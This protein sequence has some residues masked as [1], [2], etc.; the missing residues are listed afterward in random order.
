MHCRSCTEFHPNPFKQHICKHCGH[1]KDGHI[2]GDASGANTPPSKPA[3]EKVED[4]RK[5]E[6]E[7]IRKSG[8]ARKKAEEEKKKQVIR[9]CMDNKIR[10]RFSRL[11]SNKSDESKK[12]ELEQQVNLGM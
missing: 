4:Q 12:P 11:K 1:P 10:R 5:K 6:L 9:I 8:E 2:A 3:E 7:E